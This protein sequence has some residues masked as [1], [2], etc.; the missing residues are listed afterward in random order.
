MFPVLIELTETKG[1]KVVVNASRII[2]ILRADEE[3]HPGARP[4]TQISM[5]DYYIAVE[6]DVATIRAATRDAIADLM[7]RGGMG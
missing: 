3:T 6:E 4:H 1:R 7:G 5:E 2:R